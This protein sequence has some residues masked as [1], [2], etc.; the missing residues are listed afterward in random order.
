M[1]FITI[2]TLIG[3][4]GLFLYG[5][6]LM[7]EGLQKVMG[8]SLRRVLEAMTKN[9]VT[10]MLTGILVSALVQ[11]SSATT[12]M[13]VSFVNAG[14]ITLAEAMAVIMGANVGTTVTTWMIAWLGFSM[15][16]TFL[17]FPLIALSWPYLSS[18]RRG[19]NTWGEIIMGFAL[20]FLGISFMSDTLPAIST[21]TSITHALQTTDAW[22][23][24]AIPLY[25]IIGIL[26]TML[27]QASSAVFVITSVLCINFGLSFECG[28]AI[29]L[30][31]NIGTC[32]IPLIASLK[33]NLM[34]QR[35]AMGHLLFNLFGTIWAITAFGWI[36]QFVS[37][38]CMQIGLGNTEEPEGVVFGLAMYH[39]LFNAINLCVL[40]PLNKYLVIIIAKLVK[41]KE[42]KEESFKLQFI[43]EGYIALSG[44]MALLQVQKEVY[45]Y[46]LETHRMFNIANEML[47]RRVSVE[48]QEEQLKRIQLMEE[49]SDRAELEI[50][51]Y[52]NQISPATLSQSGEAHSR[53]LYKI[54]DELESIADSLLHIAVFLYQKTEQ[55]IVFNPEMSANAHK[56]MKLTE[57]SIQHMTKVLEADEVTGNA[58]NKAYNYEDEINNLRNQLRNEMLDSINRKEVEYQQNT[59]FMQLINECEK[60]GDYTINVIAAASEK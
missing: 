56:M 35:A 46:S 23:W 8:E 5:L 49:E 39:T 10:G 24:L 29:L 43:D 41:E 21:V 31:S 1:T 55:R 18:K 26:I 36:C 33:A 57:A 28:C 45:R 30:G 58:L 50:A 16:T 54:V 20:L 13:I 14:L 40:L 59:F 44:E 3:S 2:I 6:K 34:A 11:S 51:Q 53:S 17:I 27:V 38:I 19:S 9:R 12:V 32:I 48:K 37:E 52:L 25:L 7:S 47:D 4:I 15:D 22:G 42:K 60:I